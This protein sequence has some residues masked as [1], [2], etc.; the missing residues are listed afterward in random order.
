MS[1]HERTP[2]HVPDGPTWTMPPTLWEKRLRPM[3]DSL[4]EQD[5]LARAV[6]VGAAGAGKTATLHRVR[7]QL[8]RDGR[9]VQVAGSADVDIERVPPDTVLL[10]DDL[11]ACDDEQLALVRARAAD[12]DASLIVALRPWPTTIATRAITR[13]LAASLPAVLLGDIGPADMERHLSATGRGLPA[14]C[15]QHI[16]EIT[17]GVTWLVAAALAEH[18]RDGCDDDAQHSELARALDARVA[19]RLDETDEPLRGAITR[20]SVIPPGAKAPRDPLTEEE[21][22]AGQA[23]GLL[24]RNGD[25][26]PLIRRAVRSTLPAARVAELGAAAA[27]EMLRS[28][29]DD[30]VLEGMLTPTADDTVRDAVIQYA[31]SLRDSH[32]ERAVALY[33]RV[34]DGAGPETALPGLAEAHWAAGD[35]DSAIAVVDA[36]PHSADEGRLVDLAG[37]VWAARGMMRHADAVHRASADSGAGADGI[38]SVGATIAAF[39]IGSVPTRASLSDRGADDRAVRLRLPS[40]ADISADLLRRGLSASISDASESALADLVRAAE[41]YTSSQSAGPLPELPAVI[42]T[43]VALDLGLPRT[44]RA[45]IDDAIDGGHGGLWAR[46]R[47]LLWRAWIAVQRARPIDAREALDAAQGI[48]PRLSA[49]DAFLAGAVELAIARR[50]DDAS[51]LGSAWRRARTALL[52]VDTDLYLLHPLTEYLGAA[53]RM[54]ETDQTR[55]HLAEALDIVADLGDPPLWSTHVRWAG[56]QQGIL[57]GDPGVV[58]P[59]AKALVSASTDSPVAAAMARAGRIW[60]SVLAG[61]VDAP[62]VEEAAEGLA[63]VG[64]RWDGA[65]LAGHGAGRADDRKVAAR[66]LACARELHPTD[67]QRRTTE[68]APA[69]DTSGPVPEELLSERE[70]EVARLV[71]QGKTYAEIGEAIFISPRTAEHHIA[72]IRHRLGATSR[73]DVIAKLR[74]LILDD[75]VAAPPSLPLR[76]SG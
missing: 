17:A 26:L 21:I 19:H 61:H 53:A 38:D 59:H 69:G 13:S 4:T 5:S 6:L 45:I 32:P 16:L 29:P 64:L 15:R 63:A 52:H 42:A 31:G 48:M 60:T 11:Q 65:R 50:Y 2:V 71:L 56:V 10:V 14:S 58:A 33:R 62:A 36:L 73:S 20:V 54:G 49:R 55:R 47:L 28:S 70:L 41:M 3:L 68:P 44:A 66:L 8:M 34:L 46:P 22:R 76:A 30:P 74:Q 72:H 25:V 12:P 67:G 27:A 35:I 40:T 24:L 39:G 7:A 1:I 9:R 57:L 43:A 18:D 23:A 75:R 37:G 51:G